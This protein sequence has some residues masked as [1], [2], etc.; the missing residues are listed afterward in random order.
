[1][2][3]FT[4]D[5]QKFLKDLEKNN[6]RDWFNDNKQRYIND[7][8]EP[9]ELFIEDLIEA[10]KPHFESLSITPKEAI[11]RI[12][13]DVR[14]SKDKTPYKTQISALVN[15]GG[16]KGM[17][18]PGIY[19]EISAKHIRVYSGQ[20][21]PDSKQ[22]KN[23]RSHITHNMDAFTAL[24]SDDQ[25]IKTFGEI[26]GEQNKRIPKEFEADAVDQPLLFNKQFYF[27]TE[28]KSEVAL[29]EHLIK[30]VV[31]TFLIARPMS[32]FLYEGLF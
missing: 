31:N 5:L 26:R 4:K 8:K 3:Y 29:S 15:P 30:D 20:Y 13:K 32:E 10:M 19:I 25:F 6:N 9:F 12:Y 18:L 14:F 11:F 23:I 7:V 16:R 21:Q 24:I 22:L 27:F 2:A 28:W 1:M 17:S